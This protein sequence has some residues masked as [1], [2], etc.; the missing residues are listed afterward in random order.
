MPAAETRKRC[1]TRF[2]Q[3][4]FLKAPDRHLTEHALRPTRPFAAFRGLLAASQTKPARKPALMEVGLLCRG[5]GRGIAEALGMVGQRGE[6]GPAIGVA[7]ALRAVIH[8]PA[9]LF[10]RPAPG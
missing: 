8:R 7:Q 3:A 9:W 5:Q 10:R 1:S 2:G 6:I 4:R